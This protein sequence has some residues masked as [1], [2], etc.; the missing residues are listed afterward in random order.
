M[1]V[2]QWALTHIENNADVTWDGFT[3]SN[4]VGE[5]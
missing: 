3:F 5:P 1:H 4:N 2:D